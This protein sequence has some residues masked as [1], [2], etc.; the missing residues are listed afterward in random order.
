MGPACEVL[1]GA[2]EPSILDVVDALLDSIADRIE[3]TRKGRVWDLWIGGRPIHVEVGSSLTSIKLSAGCD[4]AEDYTLL[5]QLSEG[6]AA[7]C[8]GLASE[9]IK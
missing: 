5:R 7:V 3:R 8:G 6:L 1:L 2:D 4:G 9:P